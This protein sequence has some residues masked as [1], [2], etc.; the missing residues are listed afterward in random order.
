MEIKDFEYKEMD[1]MQE[2]WNALEDAGDEPF[3][4]THYELTE[5]DS[6]FTPQQW[7][8]F[9]SY[10]QVADY[11]NSEMQIMYQAKLRT[12]INELNSDT[13]S[14][15]TPQA[16]N[17]VHNIIEKGQENKKEGPAFIYCMVPLNEQ[18]IHSP[19]VQVLESNPFNDNFNSIKNN[20]K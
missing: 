12:L 15:G 3:Y 6:R 18:E 14:T 16:I 2:V 1:E 17:A 4:K 9:L 10:P 8:L 13:K 11:I 20:N 7:K 5:Y 19:N